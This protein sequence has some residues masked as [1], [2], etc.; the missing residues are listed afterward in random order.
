MTPIVREAVIGARVRSLWCSVLDP[1][2]DMSATTVSQVRAIVI[3]ENGLGFDLSIHQPP[4]TWCRWPEL[5]ARDQDL[6]REFAH[7]SGCRIEGLY[8][9]NRRP[10]VVVQIEGGQT[11]AMNSPAP[12][13]IVPEL[14]PMSEFE[15]GDLED[16]WQAG[17]V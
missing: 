7:L 3:L 10:G 15:V 17:D 14:M 9:S 1:P 16:F 6:E 4:L 13:L 5:E 2:V 11:I 8:L 12:W